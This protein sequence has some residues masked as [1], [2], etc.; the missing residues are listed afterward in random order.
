MRDQSDKAILCIDDEKIILDSLKSQ[1]NEEFDSTFK[2]ELAESADEGYEIIDELVDSGVSLLLI[3]SDWLMPN[4]KGDE[5]LEEVHKKH[6]KIVKI[7][8]TGQ[9]DQSAIDNAFDNAGLYKVIHKPWSK[10]E[11]IDSI[12]KG[13]EFKN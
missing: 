11:L 8:L 5:F 4:I 3:V 10:S 12:K 2:V 6:P 7:M 13:L 1:I 9:A